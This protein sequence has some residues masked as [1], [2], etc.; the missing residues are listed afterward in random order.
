MFKTNLIYYA[1]LKT[2]NIFTLPLQKSSQFHN[3]GIICSKTFSMFTVKRL[4]NRTTKI[5]CASQIVCN[6]VTTMFFYY[7]ELNI[8][9]NC[10]SQKK[11]D[12]LSATC[13]NLAHL[14]SPVTKYILWKNGMKNFKCIYFI[15]WEIKAILGLYW[16]TAQLEKY[17]SLL[18]IHS[19]YF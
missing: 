14:F 4:S 9:N 18:L 12:K 13:I 11:L 6:L 8:S 2:L 15:L 19:I 17:A 1:F 7:K 3:I 5:V 10:D 16:V